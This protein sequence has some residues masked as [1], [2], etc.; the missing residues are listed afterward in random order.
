M[1]HK[2]VHKSRSSYPTSII[3]S[4]SL[5]FFL[6]LTCCL[7]RCKPWWWYNMEVT[8]SNPAGFRP[9][10]FVNKFLLPAHRLTRAKGWFY[11]LEIQVFC[12]QMEQF[13]QVLG[14]SC[15]LANCYQASE[16]IAVVFFEPP[17]Q[18]WE[19][20]SLEMVGSSLIVWDVGEGGCQSGWR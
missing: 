18:I 15:H 17:T 8:P 2:T 13:Q 10:G 1:I 11:I 20:V 6:Q 16:T 9:C 19:Q 3:N 14:A 4:P 12:S 7:P 5:C